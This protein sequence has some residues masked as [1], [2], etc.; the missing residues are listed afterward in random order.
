VTELNPV[1]TRK[2]AP[3][4]LRSLDFQRSAFDYRADHMLQRAGQRLKRRMDDGMEPFDAFVDVQ[5]HLVHLAHAEAERVVLNRFAEAVDEVQDQALRETLT[6]LRRLFALSRIEADLDWFL[7]AGYVSSTKARAIRGAVNDLC[8]E[9]RPQAE[10]LVDAFAIP[11]S[12]LAAP[13]AT[14]EGAGPV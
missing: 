1:V 14:M 6:T 4:H 5:D 9:V 7:E 12:C 3:E 2:T 13:I 8:D 11:E 10:A